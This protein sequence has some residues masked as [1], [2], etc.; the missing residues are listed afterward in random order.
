VV[1]EKKTPVAPEEPEPAS[2]NSLPLKQSKR[3]QEQD[4]GST[5]R[6]HEDSFPVALPASIA[7]P[8]EPV[9][10]IIRHEETR[11]RDALDDLIDDTRAISHLVNTQ[12]YPD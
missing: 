9:Q 1:T 2:S 7:L 8:S 10:N 5:Q 4:Q 3:A 12:V 11:E 6:S